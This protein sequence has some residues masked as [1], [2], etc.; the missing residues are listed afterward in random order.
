MAV[1]AGADM[2][3]QVFPQD[4]G[5]VIDAIVEAVERGDIAE[6]RIDSS[7]RRILQAKAR[8]GLHEKRT[9]ELE[10]V[11]AALATERHLE[12]AQEAADRS[13]TAVRDHHFLLPLRGNVLSIVFAGDPD[14]WTGRTFQ[15]AL[16]GTLPDLDTA[17]LTANASPA[18]IDH[19]RA[20]AREADIVV[21]APFIRVGAYK[22]DLALPESI[23][24]LVR[25]IV[26]IRPTAI[27]SF[28]NPYLLTQFPEAGTY[29][30]AW[31]QW[32]APQRAA[33][34]A[35][36]GEIP[37]SGRLPIPLPPG[38]GIGDG[39]TI[40][41]GAAERHP[42]SPLHSPLV[43]PLPSALPDEVGLDPALPSEVDRVIRQGILE[44]AAPGAAIVVG[45]HGKQ[46]LGLSGGRL[47]RPDGEAPVTDSTIFDLASLTKVIATATAV[48]I[49]VDDGLIDLDAPVSTYLP[50]WG[51]SQ[52]H[53]VV[54][55]RHLLLHSSGL[56]AWEP[57]YQK[58]RG[59][60][61]YLLAIADMPLKFEPGTSTE[62][63]DL[64]AILLGLVVERISRQPLDVFLQDRV[65]GPLGMRDTGFRPFRWSEGAQLGSPAPT[66]D[67]FTRTLARRIAPTEVDTLFRHRHLRGE[68][69]D[70]NAWAMGGV[71]GHAGLFSSARDLA[72]FA[73]LLLDGGTYGHLRL[74]REETVRMFT[75]R[76]APG[77][78]RALGWDTPASGS[79]AAGLFSPESFGHTGYTGTSIWADPRKDLFIVLLTNRVNPSRHNSRLTP[80][81]KALHNTVQRSVREN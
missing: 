66:M 34:R 77:S 16:A 39:I 75:R 60:N 31:G 30:L 35:L 29:L 25:E 13:I 2:L 69:H 9:V 50:E 46:V 48:M 55:V 45:R 68:V 49:L 15:R 24:T 44:G 17:K 27:V 4:V 26:A 57:L 59:R 19:V 32:D 65:F 54:T 63:S 22:G 80:M 78:T 51:S 37:V 42:A 74:I 79:S 21:I 76:Q 62:Y 12:I 52:P 41:P 28:G 33:A 23:A 70:E 47:D 67:E 10:Q 20:L 71:A 3:L 18:E 56:P 38:Y 72:R 6:T 58:L 14:P 11:P 81:R 61:P 36:T 5:R 40:D 8:L 7:V 64:G 73:Q 53:S 43:V 1:K